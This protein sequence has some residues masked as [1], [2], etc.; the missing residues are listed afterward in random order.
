MNVRVGTTSDVD[1]HTQLLHKVSLDSGHPYTIRFSARA[2]RPVKISVGV[3]EE[4]GSWQGFFQSD[5]ELVDE[6]RNYEFSFAPSASCASAGLWFRKLAAAKAEYRFAA[7]SFRRG[8]RI[9]GM[10]QG[11]VDFASLP[12]FLAADKGNRTETAKQDW[13]SFLVQKERE[14]WTEM[15]G[16][17]RSLGAHALIHGTQVGFSTPNLMSDLISSTLTDTGT[18]PPPRGTGGIRHGGCGQQPR[19]GGVGGPHQ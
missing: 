17:L 14:Y 3:S 9:A 18:T 7:V 15:Y 4:G 16:Y 2:D 13:V 10:K 12:I 8:G 19:R 5:V 1:W 11:E 6:W